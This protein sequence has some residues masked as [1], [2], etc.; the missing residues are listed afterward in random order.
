MSDNEA[1]R[2]MA[3]GVNP[4]QRDAGHGNVSVLG[5]TVKIRGE[6]SADEDLV[7]KG[8]VEGYISH[9]K[10]L[11]ISKQGNVT[12]NTKAASVLVE[13]KIRGD[14][15]GTKGVLIRETSEVTGNIYSPCVSLLEGAKF[16]GAID[17]EKDPAAVAKSL[18]KSYQVV[19]QSQPTKLANLNPTD[20]KPIDTAEFKAASVRSTQSNS[21]SGNQ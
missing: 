20:K 4:Y 12:A 21:N 10:H 9:K 16:K 2:S 18:K 5:P 14:I 19:E 13:G 3:E 1:N 7:I 17:M 11:T 8:T 15:C 6:L